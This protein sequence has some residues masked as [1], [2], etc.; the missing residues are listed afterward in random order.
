[1]PPAGPDEHERNEVEA[2]ILPQQLGEGDAVGVRQ[3]LGEQHEVGHLGVEEILRLARVPSLHHADTGLH[4]VGGVGIGHGIGVDDHHA[5]RRGTHARH[6]ARE[7]GK[8]RIH[9]LGD[10]DLVGARGHGAHAID[11]CGGLDQH[12][13]ARAREPARGPGRDGGVGI[14]HRIL[15]GDDDEVRARGRRRRLR[16]A[17][18]AEMH[19]EAGRPERADGALAKEPRLDHHQCA[20]AE[21]RLSRRFPHTHRLE[22]LS[23]RID[24]AAQQREAALQVIGA[25]GGLGRRV[26]E[27]VLDLACQRGNLGQAMRRRR[28]CELVDPRAKPL[29]RLAFA[30]TE[31]FCLL[32]QFREPGRGFSEVALPECPVDALGLRVHAD[33]PSTSIVSRAAATNAGAV[34]Q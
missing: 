26:R 5:R 7:P 13:R 20:P 16:L 22:G 23:R 27:P 2:R 30:G 10:V 24:G 14:L 21:L 19:V 6:Q 32:P 1:M 29:R 9:L 28:S 34:P 17:R 4:E 18:I 15:G 8:F 31:R 12:H 11:R 3:V 25:L 33:L